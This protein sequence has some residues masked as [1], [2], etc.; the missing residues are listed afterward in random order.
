VKLSASILEDPRPAIGFVPDPTP[1]RF[2]LPVAPGGYAWWYVDAVSEDGAHALTMIAFV[3]S[4]FSPNYARARRAM[5][6]GGRSADPERFCAINVALYRK[7]DRRCWALT[8]HGD[9]ERSRELLTIGQTSL[10]WHEDQRGAHLLVEVDERETRFGGR[11]GPPI[12]G[13]IRLYPSASFGP[14]IELDRARSS[15]RH[16][17]Y[18]VAPHAE[19]VVEFDAPAL[20]FAGSGYHDVNEGDEGLELG[21]ASWNWSR[22]KLDR[23]RTAILYDV[24]TREAARTD[25]RGW[26]F[27]PERREITEIDAS[28][29]GPEVALPR[30]RWRVD[31]GIRSEVGHPPRLISTL[32]DTPFYSRNLV[33]VRIADSETT[34]VHESLS[35]ERFGSRAVQFLLRFKTNARATSR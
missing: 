25:P 26:L 32:E 23:G 11:R 33:R 3:G 17:W 16:R 8:E 2:D 14:R 1:L 4:V 6:S 19:V 9:V 22:A 15:A 7:H 12:R 21:F 28:T 18:P 20:R 34:A 29:L 31:R 13:R 24:V 10:R 35:L 27:V 30:T 5:S